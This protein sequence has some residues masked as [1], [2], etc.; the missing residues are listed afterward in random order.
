MIAISN[1]FIIAR[2]KLFENIKRGPLQ[3]PSDMS[4]EALDLIVKLLNR[5]PKKRLGAGPGDAEEI[6]EHPFFNT[7][8]WEEALER[9]LKPPKPYIKPIIETG[10]K[11]EAF[12]E[13]E[14]DTDQNKMQKWTFISKD[15]Q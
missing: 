2:Q 4:K 12:S 5:D 14:E 1:S 8:N 7:I 10:G 11:F 13:L 6:K 9:K 15:F 3:V